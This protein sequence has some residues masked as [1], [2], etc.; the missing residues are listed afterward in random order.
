MN[1]FFAALRIYNAAENA[2][3]SAQAANRWRDPLARFPPSYA[4]TTNE[5]I[6]SMSTACVLGRSAG[7]VWITL[8]ITKKAVRGILA[9]S[10]I[11][12][13]MR[14]RGPTPFR[15]GVIPD[16]TVAGKVRPLGCSWC[17]S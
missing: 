12:D 13:V 14:A 3:N 10:G 11:T 8:A 7:P 5:A 4:K 1:A 6:H 17:A 9:A 16:T 15:S 2:P